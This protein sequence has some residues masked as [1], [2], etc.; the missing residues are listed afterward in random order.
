VQI[1]LVFKQL[2]VEVLCLGELNESAVHFVVGG[3]H[4]VG[5]DAFLFKAKKKIVKAR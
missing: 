1:S 5:I 4:L 2:S 3:V